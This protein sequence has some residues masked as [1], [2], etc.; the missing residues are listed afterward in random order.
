[1]LIEPGFY[2]TKFRTPLDESSGVLLIEDDWVKGGDSAM[3]YV[4]EISGEP[5]KIAVRMRVR[6]HD[7]DKYSVFGDVTDF[8]L[9]LTGRK[10]G[11]AYTFEGRAD[12]APSLRFEA[13][14]TPAPK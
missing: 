10:K 5:N 7:L 6:Q 3:F 2:I 12:R 14:M 11:A 1:M 13:T 9:T 4:G 8:M